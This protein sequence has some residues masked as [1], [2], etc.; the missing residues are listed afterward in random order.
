MITKNIKISKSVWW[1]FAT[2]LL[3]ASKVWAEDDIPPIHYPLHW[4][5]KLVIFLH[6]A[7]QFLMGFFV[8]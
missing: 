4:T 8:A 7:W 3:T 5:E 6:D 1:I 2:V